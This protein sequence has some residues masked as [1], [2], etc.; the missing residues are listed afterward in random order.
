MQQQAETSKPAAEIKPPAAPE[1]AVAKPVEPAS[2]APV[3]PPK[4]EEPPKAAEA[5][6]APPV[7]EPTKP[8]EPP[9]DTKPPISVE[10]TPPAQPAEASFIDE[11]P[12]LVYGGGGLVALL[13][14]YLGFSAWRRKSGNG[15]DVS[16]VS[17]LS[18]GDLMA[19]SVFG[20]TGGQ[21]VDTSA[22]IQTDFSQASLSAIDTDEGVDPV[23]EADVYMAYGRDAQAE[24]IL[25][26][27][28]K[29]DPSR[30]AIYLKLLEIYSGHK[31]LSK[32]EKVATD[33]R[34]Q[35]G[36]LGPDWDKATAMG[37]AIDPGNP[38]YAGGG[39]VVEQS[40]V[41]VPEVTASPVSDFSATSAPERLKDTVTLPGQLSQLAETAV[42]EDT[43]AP[44]NLGFDL[45]LGKP[46]QA[47]EH[48]LP[49]TSF[50]DLSVGAGAAAQVPEID[51]SLPEVVGKAE[52]AP[53][54]TPAE[55]GGGLD[56][57]FDLDA[58]PAAAPAPVIAE[59]APIDFS[60]INL[61][62][63][64]SSAPA[65]E[66]T[67]PVGLD[68]DNADVTTKLELAQAYEEMGDREGAREL[69]EEV[70][71]EGSSHQQEIARTKLAAL[72]A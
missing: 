41:V 52:I 10:A 1:P 12:A 51:L 67:E 11:N 69:L 31:N 26:D 61:D 40:E 21:A 5:P 63:V 20:S 64:T 35:T 27:A 43:L 2:A 53:K 50:V 7:V 62:L 22:S 59:A 6:V 70:L 33:L 60:G 4:A 39:D 28:L 42:S 38:L 16:T 58:P 18:E 56:F 15:G 8:A 44:V 17:R 23:A 65:I 71:Q 32:F 14:G 13:L 72:D 48:K 30:L 55:A 29:T 34:G 46:S 3:E 49:S 54:P 36:G 9:V 25:I 19:N 37:R 45:D 57:E 24:E 68:S 47:D 66:M